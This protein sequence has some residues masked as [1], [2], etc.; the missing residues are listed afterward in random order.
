[1]SCRCE[2]M[3]QQCRT[4]E[5]TNQWGTER[6]REEVSMEILLR[7]LKET[8]Y[9]AQF[10]RAWSP[11]AASSGSWSWTACRNPKHCSCYYVHTASVCQ[12]VR[13][14]F[15]GK[16]N[17]PKITILVKWYCSMLTSPRSARLIDTWTKYAQH[18]WC[19][20]H[21]CFNLGQSSNNNIAI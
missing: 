15:E 10:C 18:T 11:R 1:M 12:S 13:R 2:T 19:D 20:G 3:L 8:A 6:V 9:R 16:A 14:L 4:K 5:R 7:I 21:G 17:T